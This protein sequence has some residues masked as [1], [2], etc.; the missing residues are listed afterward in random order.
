[1]DADVVQLLVANIPSLDEIRLGIKHE[2][3]RL[4]MFLFYLFIYFFFFARTDTLLC[5]YSH[6]QTYG[7]PTYDQRKL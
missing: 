1:M 7:H 6:S 3:F 2:I 5:I 4:L